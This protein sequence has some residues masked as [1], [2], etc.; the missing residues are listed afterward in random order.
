MIISILC[1]L[2]SAK[3]DYLFFTSASKKALLYGKLSSISRNQDNITLT[4]ITVVDD[5]LNYPRN[6]V[7]YEKTHRVYV[8][9]TI[10]AGFTQGYIYEY[11]YTIGDLFYMRIVTNRSNH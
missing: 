10:Y 2:N 3:S 5:T 7:A 8:C 9:D 4:N 6:V 1:L 11:E